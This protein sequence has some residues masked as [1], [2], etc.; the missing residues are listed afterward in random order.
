MHF[1]PLRTIKF[2]S[3]LD[4]VIS[5]DDSGIIEIWDPETFDFPTDEKKLK[6]ELISD[7]DF[8]ELAKIK[9]CAL[10]CT[11]S[12]SGEMIAFYCKDRKIRIFTIRNGKLIKTIDETL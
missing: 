5:T 8:L 2:L 3:H 6:F 12:N 10:S 11:V 7:T 4:L 9:T 1:S